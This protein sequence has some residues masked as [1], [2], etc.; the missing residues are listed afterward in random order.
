M[1]TKCLLV[2]DEPPA[3]DLLNKH[4]SLFT[5]MEVSATC[6]NAMQAL[7]VLR[8]QPI[9]LMFLD[10]E[11]P[12][13]S[14]FDFLKT[15]QNPPKV[16]VTTAYREYASEGYDLDVVDYLLK[17]ISLQRFTKAI[18]RYYSR[19]HIAQGYSAISSDFFYVNIN[20]KN[21]KV[22]FQDILFIES[23]KDYT[24]I[25]MVDRKLIV[26]GNIGKM[27]KQLPSNLFKRVHRSYIVSLQRITAYTQH[28]VEVE[29]MEIPLGTSYKADVFQA[30][31]TPIIPKQTS[32]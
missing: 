32:L 15:L 6:F 14:G 12:K 25:H 16:I 17:P 8:D 13:L 20:K 10:I 23:L 24:R 19:T 9:D 27:E 3:I 26:K 28:D 22:P 30:L 1:I 4:L 2:D 11:M 7:E 21:I 18:E 29:H 5:D 31:N